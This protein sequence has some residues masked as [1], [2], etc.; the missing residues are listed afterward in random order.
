M[1]EDII[2]RSKICQEK[3]KKNN[4]PFFDMSGNR[5]EKIKQVIKCIEDDIIKQE[6]NFIIS[7]RW[8]NIKHKKQAIP[9]KVH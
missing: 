9:L 4:V 1:C 6:S 8:K 3:C 2:Q 5:R 7:K